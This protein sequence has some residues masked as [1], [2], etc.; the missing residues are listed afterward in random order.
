MSK[1]KSP[2]IKLSE[3]D[4][5]ASVGNII[6]GSVCAMTLTGFIKKKQWFA[7]I[8]VSASFIES[9]GKMRLHWRFEGKISKDKIDRLTLDETI[10]FLHASGVIKQQTYTKM[11]Q[12]RDARNRVAHKVVDALKIEKKPKE[13]KK[14]IEQTIECLGVLLNLPFKE[15]LS[16]MEKELKTAAKK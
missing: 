8:I 10:M 16:K 6:Y 7:G 9:I 4:K 3:E 2:K 14:T 12:V 13:A 15:A 1:V 5:I 11:Q